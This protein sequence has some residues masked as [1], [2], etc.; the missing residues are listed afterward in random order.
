MSSSFNLKKTGFN[1]CEYGC[2]QKRV[3]RL[4]CRRAY[5]GNAFLPS[6][7]FNRLSSCP[8]KNDLFLYRTRKQYCSNE[9]RV[10]NIEPELALS[11]EPS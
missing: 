11:I 6:S 8:G 10:L 1:H 4:W 9:A 2:L 3:S 5:Q 7:H